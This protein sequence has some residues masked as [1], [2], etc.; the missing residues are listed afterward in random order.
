MGDTFFFTVI[1]ALLCLSSI[2]VQASLPSPV[3]QVVLV[4][5]HGMEWE[6]IQDFNGNQSQAFGVMNTRVGGGLGVEGA[7]LSISAGARGVGTAGAGSFFM[8]Y[9]PN[10]FTLHTGLPPG[11][12]VQPLI[13][14]VITGQEVNYTVIPGALGSALT[15]AGRKVTAYGNS[16]T[17]EP[18]RWA[19]MVAMDQSGRVFDG[20]VGRRILLEDEDYPYGVRTNYELLAAYVLANDSDLIVVDLGDPYRFGEYVP[21]LMSHQASRLRERMRNEGRDFLTRLAAQIREDS[22]IVAAAPYPGTE[23][24]E[25]GQWLTPILFLGMGSGLPVSGTTRWPGL[26]TNMDIAPTILELLG[27]EESEPMIGRSVR[28][29][30]AYQGYD[31]VRSLEE[32]LLGVAR[33]RGVV[34]RILVA[35]QIVLYIGSLGLLITNRIVPKVAIQFFQMALIIWLALPGCLFAL[36]GGAFLMAVFGTGLILTYFFT[37]SSVQTVMA[38]ALMTGGLIILDI[39]TGGWLI[40]FSYLGY[41]A[42]GGA[43]FYGLGNEYMGIL[44]GSVIMGWALMAQLSNF[45]QWVLQGVGIILFAGALVII[46]APSWGTNVGGAITAVLGFGVTLG[47]VWNMKIRLRTVLMVLLLVGAVL[48]LLMAVDSGKPVDQQSHIGQTVSLLKRDGWKAIVSI[49][50]RKRSMNFKLMRYSIWSR[51]FIAAL[52]VMGASFIWPSSFIRW[53]VD[54]Y[55][56]IAKGIGGVVVG[57]VGALVFN[58]SGVVAAATPS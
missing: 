20:D 28:I 58:D 51:A 52:G 57:S 6:D 9:E 23:R 25:Q 2:L 39:V 37:Q 56:I 40:R 33:Y 11:S 30:P 49:I 55:P 43:R 21:N 3:S 18:K 5:W 45:P 32:R 22:V 44:I 4:L 48:G 16:D 38:A 24:V 1:F 12:I 47:A 26:I 46:G 15:A 36:S 10:H 41:D 17:V 14:Q 19:G 13:G 34:L 53:L 29:E 7:Y 50:Q 8:D 35:I 54:T 42:V 31:R 27:V